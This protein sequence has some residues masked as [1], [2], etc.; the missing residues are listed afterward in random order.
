MA[1]GPDGFFDKRGGMS[2]PM[3]IVLKNMC[4]GLVEFT[5]SLAPVVGC[6]A[7]LSPVFMV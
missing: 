5:D 1:V 6:T 2:G 7:A 3:V 4:V